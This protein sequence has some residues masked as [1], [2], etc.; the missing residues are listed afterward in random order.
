MVE[1]LGMET[2]NSY[3]VALF[4]F[5]VPYILFEDMHEANEKELLIARLATDVADA[6]MNLHGIPR[7]SVL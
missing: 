6:K 3:N 4:I 7:R 1:E 5:F 2:G